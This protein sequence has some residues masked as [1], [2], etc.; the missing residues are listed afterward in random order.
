MSAGARFR[1]RIQARV[2]TLVAVGMLGPLAAILFIGSGSQQELERRVLAGRTLTASFVAERLQALLSSELETLRAVAHSA[3]ADPARAGPALREAWVQRHEIFD[4]V[5]AVDRAGRVLGQEPAEDPAVDGPRAVAEAGRTGGPA[6]TDLLTSGPGRLHVYALVPI[7]GGDGKLAGAIGGVID[8][9]SARFASILRGYRSVSGE[10][11]DLVDGAG[12]VLAS[13]NPARVRLSS[14][15]EDELIARAR[16]SV[17]RWEVAVRQPRSEAL[18]FDVSRRALAA[19]VLALAIALAFAWGASRSLTRPLSALTAAAERISKGQ[20]AEP[21][22][23]LD[24]DEVGL[25]GRALER[26]RATLEDSIALL[27]SRVAERTADLARVN[28]EL[29]AREDAVR[30]LLG[31]I[32]GAQEDERRRVARELHDETTQSLTTLAMRIQTAA[33]AAPPGEQRDH[34]E[35]AAVLAERTLDGVHRLIVDLRPAVLDDLGLKSAILWYAE[36]HL[37]PLGIAVRCE[38]SDLDGR[39]P[40]QL[41]TAVFRVVQE[42]LTNVARHAQASSVLIQAARRHGRL[43]LEI[44]DDGTG[45]DPAARAAPT[46]D[47]SGWGL[48]GMRERVEMLGGELRIDSAPREGTHLALWVPLTDGRSTLPAAKAPAPGEEA[49]HG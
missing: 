12:A 44:E 20:L 4:A 40:A 14:A 27:E 46:P 17:A 26:M 38:F 34:L 8:P 1:H 3:R 9:G 25:L 41:E 19:S 33:A 42:A 49:A 21:I 45:F 43:T 29:R 35:A 15:G 24:D 36:K 31:K 7:R 6:F 23:P 48:L 39:L 11:I 47:G 30:Q 13:S 5:F 22:P 32:I 18:G 28:Q 37:E 16:I 10:S 2:S